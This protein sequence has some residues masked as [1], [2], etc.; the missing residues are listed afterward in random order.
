M[1]PPPGL[2]QIFKRVGHE[3]PPALTTN[4]EN[5]RPVR[6]LFSNELAMSVLRRSQQIMKMTT[7]AIC[8]TGV[9]PVKSLALYMGE[10]PMLPH[11][12]FSF[13]NES[14]LLFYCLYKDF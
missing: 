2:T 12:L 7:G 5:D 9:S 1:L 3:R 10:T 8:N 6:T 11:N 4:D 14:N 13:S